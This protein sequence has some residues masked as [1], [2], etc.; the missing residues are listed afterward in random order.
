[1]ESILRMDGTEQAV[2][3]DERGRPFVMEAVQDTHNGV[4]VLNANGDLH[5]VYVRRYLY[6]KPAEAKASAGY[7]QNEIY[8]W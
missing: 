6:N 5:F 8:T 4:P 7:A 1:M 3:R 2:Q